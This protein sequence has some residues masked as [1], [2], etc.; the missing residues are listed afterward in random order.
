MGSRIHAIMCA[1]AVA[2]QSPNEYDFYYTPLS[3]H[4]ANDNCERFTHGMSREDI[5]QFDQFMNMGYNEK[6]ITNKTMLN[7]GDFSCSNFKYKVSLKP[8]Y[9]FDTNALEYLRYKYFVKNTKFELSNI[10][11]NANDFNVGIHIRRGDIVKR[12][13]IMLP[14]EY[15]VAIM[16]D[17]L[18]NNKGKIIQ[19]AE[20]PFTFHIFSEYN[21]N[22]SQFEETVINM[23]DKEYV[24]QF[25]IKYHIEIPL[26]ETIHG[27]IS[28]DVLVMSKSS[29]S[30][31]CAILSKGIIY[32][33]EYWYHPLNHWIVVH[34]DLYNHWKEGWYEYY[35]KWWENSK[36]SKSNS[37][38]FQKEAIDIYEN[39]NCTYKDHHNKILNNQALIRTMNTDSKYKTLNVL[40]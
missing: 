5:L 4:C 40:N 24:N 26:N 27:L 35:V 17:I 32:Y 23:I 16:N 19:D 31:I 8:S 29:L 1:M 12:D 37:R 3:I 34:S 33:P 18:H 22:V 13:Y 38:Y 9:Y 28:S 7:N 30:Y 6:R 36:C 20:T 14:D 11:F 39:I 2:K 21:F 25:G 15:Y 10:G